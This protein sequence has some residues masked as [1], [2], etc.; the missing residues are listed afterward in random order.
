MADQNVYRRLQIGGWKELPFEPFRTGVEIHMLREGEPAL[1]LLRY[2]QGA[3][4][5]AHLHPDVE[6]ILVLEGSQSDDA[7]TYNAGDF[8]INQPGSSHRV[9]SDDGCVVL[10]SWSKPVEFLAVE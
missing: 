9:W 8:V 2:Q 4:V 5:P 1:A 3:S 7:G 10:I 6:T